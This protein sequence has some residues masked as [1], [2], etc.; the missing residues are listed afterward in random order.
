VLLWL[1]FNCDSVFSALVLVRLYSIHILLLV[2]NDLERMCKG[3]IVI[4]F[5]TLLWIFPRGTEGKKR[6]KEKEKRKTLVRLA[7]YS[8]LIRNLS[9]MLINLISQITRELQDISR[10]VKMDQKL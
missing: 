1:L 7:I 3:A 6:K 8:I 10:N 9:N 2:N 5:K 4:L